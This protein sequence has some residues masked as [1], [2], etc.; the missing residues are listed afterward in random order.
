MNKYGLYLLLGVINY[1]VIDHIYIYIQI[2]IQP[3]DHSMI[4]DL[5][6]DVKYMTN[7]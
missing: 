3:D 1:N 7:G 2:K 4:N 5:P 6:M